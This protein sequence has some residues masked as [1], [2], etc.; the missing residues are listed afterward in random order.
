M[1]TLFEALRSDLE[2]DVFKLYR[3]HFN[4]TYQSI[5]FL[6]NIEKID[7]CSLIEKKVYLPP[8]LQSSY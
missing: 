5:V 2:S 6:N 1:N 3:E 7:E 4:Q 8:N